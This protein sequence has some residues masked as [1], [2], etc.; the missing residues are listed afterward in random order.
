MGWERL[1]CHR[2]GPCSREA[3]L[4]RLRWNPCLN[5]QK[6]KLQICNLIQARKASS[7]QKMNTA[8]M[9]T[10]VD[11]FELLP[12]LVKLL[13]HVS[14]VKPLKPG[15]QLGQLAMDLL[16]LDLELVLHPVLELLLEDL[17]LAYREPS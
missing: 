7:N 17:G 2:S 10:S 3:G 5:V 1:T 16:L 15:G 8:K 13:V 14:S 12:P 9:M 4:V 6:L 11:N